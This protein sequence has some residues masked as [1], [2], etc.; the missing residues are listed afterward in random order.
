MAAPAQVHAINAL[1]TPGRTSVGP[2]PC[3]LT[4]FLGESA[5][6]AA[7]NRR[8]TVAIERYALARAMFMATPPRSVVKADGAAPAPCRYPV[9]YRPKSSMVTEPTLMS[10]IPTEMLVAPAGIAGVVQLAWV[11][12]E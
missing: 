6:A 10:P 9:A 1:H 7:P 8:R 5:L 2:A 12:V 4:P 3:P 11:Q